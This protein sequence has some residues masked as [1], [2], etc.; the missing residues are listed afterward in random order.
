MAQ[1]WVHGGRED[2]TERQHDSGSYRNYLANSGSR[3]MACQAG[4]T[5]TH[6]RRWGEF[7]RPEHVVFEPKWEVRL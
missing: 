7:V 2:I 3:V 5:M 6:L 4:K 1:R